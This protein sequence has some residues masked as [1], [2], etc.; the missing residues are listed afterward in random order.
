MKLKIQARHIGKIIQEQSPLILTALGVAGTVGTAVLVAKASW[1]ASAQVDA[2]AIES[3]TALTKKEQA[4]KVWKLYIPA[5]GV[6]ALTITCIVAA[7]RI[8]T[9]R[10]A[11]IV[12]GYAVLSGDFDD[13]REKASEML[14][15]KKS[16]ELDTARGKKLMA[17]ATGPNITGPMPD[18]KS[19]FLDKT[20]KRWHITTMETI[21]G[22]QNEINYTILNHGDASLND[23]YAQIGMDP[24]D[25]GDKVGWNKKNKVELKF[26]SIL[27]EDRGAV[28]VF[29]FV[30]GPVPNHWKWDKSI[31]TD[32]NDL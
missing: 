25:L 12:A 30:R 15:G 27:T 10:L 19:W 29:E 7:N 24:C 16:A 17:E 4:L 21:K 13:Y 14:G 22:A 20:T 18:G 23:F 28:G 11:A 9:R 26:T 1:K 31:D 5:V 6:G 8:Q 2:V 3:G 32:P